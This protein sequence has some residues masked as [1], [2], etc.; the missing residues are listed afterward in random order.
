MSDR[1]VQEQSA[2]LVF[3]YAF[4]EP[5]EKVWRAI[6]IP[7]LRENWLPS[8]VL[9]DPEPVSTDPGAEVRYRLREDKPPFLES[10]VTLQI[11]PGGNGGTLLTIVHGLVE[12]KRAGRISP[13][14]N[15]NGTSVMRAA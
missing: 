15:T 1:D 7:E 3:E 13:A 11:R 2:D 14:A 8:E 4:D 5:P 12:A 9:A 6:S 10:I